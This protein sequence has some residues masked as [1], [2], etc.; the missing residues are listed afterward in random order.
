MILPKQTTCAYNYIN[1]SAFCVASVIQLYRLAFTSSLVIIFQ[2]HKC[3][4]H[5]MKAHTQ[6]VLIPHNQLKS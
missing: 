5:I 3:I 1:F 2:F 6:N 4:L